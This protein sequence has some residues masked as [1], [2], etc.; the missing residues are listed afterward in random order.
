MTCLRLVPRVMVPLVLL[1]TISAA[2]G[3]A[4]AQYVV[5]YNPPTAAASG[6]V[7]D[8]D[9]DE[10]FTIEARDNAGVVR[11]ALTINAGDRGTGDG[12]A[13]RWSIKRESS[14]IRSIRFVGRRTVPGGFGLGFDN[15]CSRS[16]AV[17]SLLQIS[18]DASV[19][20]DF[21]K[22]E[23]RPEAEGALNTAA[24]RLAAHPRRRVI[25]EG[26]TDNRGAAA[27][28]L[29]LSDQRAAVVLRYLQ[30]RT[31]AGGLTFESG[32]YGDTR[33]CRRTTRKK[34]DSGTEG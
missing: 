29:R 4:G 11:Q 1:F 31:A 21:D 16:S 28:N 25:V 13:T 14:D 34:V 27:Y 32:G 10:T 6:E 12:I 8:I 5:T 26:H 19:L 33:R 9:F 7:L 30:S 24:E 15:F 18:L 23:L 20:F 3:S 2:S 22:S 17:G